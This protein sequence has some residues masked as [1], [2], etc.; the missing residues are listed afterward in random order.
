MKH[1]IHYCENNLKKG[2]N[3]LFWFINN[4]TDIL[5]KLRAK[6]FQASTIST[7]DFSSLYA[8]LPNELID[9]IENTFR[10][11]EV[12]DLACNEEQ[13]FSLQKNIKKIKFMDLS[14]SGRRACSS[15]EQY[16]Y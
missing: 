10:L 1:W 6:V 9:L 5:N 12:L 2:R 8:T 15:F 4:H 16:L 13:L 14:K 7:F 11:E 3:K